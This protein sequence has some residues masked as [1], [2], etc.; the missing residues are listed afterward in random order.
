MGFYCIKNLQ[1]SNAIEL[2]MFIITTLF[3]LWQF[4]GKSFTWFCL[5]ILK[6]ILW[7][8]LFG[9]D[10]RVNMDKLTVSEMVQ[11]IELV[12]Q[13]DWFICHIFWGHGLEIITL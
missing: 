10:S 4:C 6:Q 2:P 11:D 13:R 9:S 8:I 1:R 3:I 5:D 12:G 7:G